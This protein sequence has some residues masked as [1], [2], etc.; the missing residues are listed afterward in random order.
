MYP[1]KWYSTFALF[2]SARWYPEIEGMSPLGP[3]ILRDQ[4]VK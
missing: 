1:F 4:Y 2:A 3:P